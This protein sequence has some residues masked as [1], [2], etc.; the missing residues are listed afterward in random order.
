MP[1]HWS[2]EE[3][4]ALES[5]F[6]N[7][8][9]GEN[10]KQDDQ[11]LP[12]TST[13][14]RTTT[15]QFDLDANCVHEVCNREDLTPEDL[16]KMYYRP[17]EY[18]SISSWNRITLKIFRQRSQEG[19]MMEHASADDGHCIRGLEHRL[20]AQRHVRQEII[21][22]GVY[23]VLDEQS[24]QRRSSYIAVVVVDADKV[25][26]AYIS[27]TCKSGGEAHQKG[28]QDERTVQE[29]DNPREELPRESSR[30]ACFDD[31]DLGYMKDDD[32]RASLGMRTKGG[33]KD[34][35]DLEQEE[36]FQTKA[37]RKE[38]RMKKMFRKLSMTHKSSPQETNIEKSD[39]PLPP[40]IRPRKRISRR[41]SM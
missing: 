30:R 39:T 1:P 35:P 34:D 36:S 33:Q 24:R 37:K 9:D 18:A 4:Q 17:T 41:S 31:N 40:P 3:F 25:A 5:I 8:P 11:P 23:S 6:D 26:E 16:K 14:S 12:D 38:G 27:Q 7:M 29:L 20:K 2:L 28:V 10:S 13:P 32:S 21:T 22:N 19:S 15:I